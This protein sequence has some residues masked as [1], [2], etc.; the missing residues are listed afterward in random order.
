MATRSTIAILRDDNTV[1]KVYCHW[2]GYLENNGKLLVENYDTADKVEALIAGGDISSLGKVV[3]SKHPFDVFLKDKMSP[4]DRALAELAEA[5]D[6]T[7]Y[8]GRD[9]GETGT[10]AKVYKDLGDYEANAQ[11]EEFNYC[12]IYGTWYYTSYDGKV[13]SVEEELEK[14][15]AEEHV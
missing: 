9:R 8:Y 10:E 15:A 12:F 4:E 6:W 5:E 11:F 3:G 1:A 13:R 14:L 2:D 7:M